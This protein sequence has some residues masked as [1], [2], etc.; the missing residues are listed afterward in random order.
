[1]SACGRL[2]AATLELTKATPIKQRL[3][4]TYSGHL[5]KI[6]LGDLPASLRLEARSLLEAFV[7]VAPLRGESAVQ[8]TVRKLSSGESEALAARVV[9]LYGQI[10]R[11]SA[12]RAVE[13]A[14]RLPEELLA[15][16]TTGEA[17]DMRPRYAT[18]F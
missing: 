16:G 3:M 11:L 12:P 6:D 18:G 8:A 10:A 7:M 17:A 1:M 9:A 2:H 13:D 14:P 15:D 5:T 4:D